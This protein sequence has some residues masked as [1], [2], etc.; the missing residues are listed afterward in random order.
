VVDEWFADDNHGDLHKIEDLFEFDTTGDNKLFNVDATLQNFTTTAGAKKLARYRWNWRKRAVS[1]S[2]NAYTNLFALVDAVNNPNNAA[3]TAQ[4]EALM[5]V[6]SWVRAFC[7]EHIAGNW[8]SYG[9]GRGKNMYAYKPDN[10]KWQLLA[11]DIDFVLGSGGDSANTDMF[12]NVNDPTIAKMLNHPPFRRAY[13]RAME[14]AVNG[15]LLS[16]KINPILDAKYS[17]LVANG[18]SVNNPSAIKTFVQDGAISL[19]RITSTQLPLI[20][21]SPATTETTSA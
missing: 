18:V 8:D 3:Y 19:S 6:E 10:G 1:D 16:T 2:A 4:T 9:Y 21:P 14:D 13:F 11:W 5:D 7:V 12:A 15:P 17:A 20:S